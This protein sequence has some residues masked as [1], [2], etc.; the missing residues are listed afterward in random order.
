VN[1][2]FFFFQF[3]NDFWLENVEFSEIKRL[4]LGDP[5]FS[6]KQGRKKLPV[7]ICPMTIKVKIKI[8]KGKVMRIIVK[9]NNISNDLLSLGMGT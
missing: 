8:D 9:E 6:I 7:K 1:K 4:P 5:R 2:F 3:S